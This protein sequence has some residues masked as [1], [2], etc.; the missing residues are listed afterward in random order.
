MRK[1]VSVIVAATVFA[2]VSLIALSGNIV[3]LDFWTG[4]CIALVSIAFA[5]LY[6]GFKPQIHDF[7]RSGEKV[8]SKTETVPSRNKSIE[9]V[10]LLP[11]N[12]EITN[13]N[14]DNKL[15]D[16]IYEQANRKAIEM[17]PDALFTCFTVQVH[18]FVSMGSKVNI[19]MHFFSKFS[20]KTCS[21]S[22]TEIFPTVE[23]NLPDRP[24]R[25]VSEIV[26]LTTLPWGASPHW[27]QFLRRAIHSKGPFAP[28]LKTCYHLT[29]NSALSP[30][31]HLSVSDGFN[32]NEY[33]FSWDGKG[34][35]EN[36]IK[37]LR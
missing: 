3:W 25:N 26:A 23:H 14:V 33:A 15:L 32:G 22:Y 13:L 35:D 27:I 4:L 18:P 24:E 29:A 36:S 19:Y 9:K 31:W 6:W 16:E 10:V 8:Q 5:V 7:F 28:S 37:Q 30:I 34:L 20:K 12:T 11:E 1:T 17:Y 21:F 2:V